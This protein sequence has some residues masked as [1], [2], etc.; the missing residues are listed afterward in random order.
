MSNNNRSSWYRNPAIIISSAAAIL[1]AIIGV[2]LTFLSN[3]PLSDFSISL[4]PTQGSVNQGSVIQFTAIIKSIHGY[5][6]SVRLSASGQ[7]HNVIVTLI[8]PYGEAK[9]AYTSGVLIDI[10]QNA[11]VGDYTIII[12]GTGADGKEHNSTYALTVKP[13]TS[14]PTPTP[15]PLI[16]KIIS[17]REGNEVPVS[18]II[19]G[20]ISGELPERRYMWVVI[21]PHTNPGLWWPQGGRINPWKGKWNAQAQFGREKEDIGTKFDIAV[22]LV[23]EKDDQYYLN[24]L[25]TGQETGNYS[26]IPLPTSAE[27]KDEITVTRR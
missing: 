17:P 7:P 18:D 15:L 14:A 21:N 23:N 13:I 19:T 16:I 5:D 26:G 3:P 22:V 11:P 6:Y 10:G 4:D 20:T 24:Y 9:P 2:T 1:A 8:P 27:I 25:K 12:K